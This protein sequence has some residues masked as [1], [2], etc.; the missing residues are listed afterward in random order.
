MK[1]NFN[2]NAVDFNGN[3]IKVND[4]P[5]SVSEEI[6]KTLFYAGNVGNEHLTNEEKYLAYKIGRKI[7]SGDQEYT[8]EELAFIKRM[9]GA[10]MSAGLFG[11]VFDLIEGSERK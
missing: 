4:K 11:I 2:V 8:A 10:T 7:A 5:L 3:E 6:C 1:I 9:T